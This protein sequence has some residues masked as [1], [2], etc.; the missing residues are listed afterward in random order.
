M[1]EVT[2][3]IQSLEK[4]TRAI[5]N[6]VSYSMRMYCR[7]DDSVNRELQSV[8]SKTAY[9]YTGLIGVQKITNY[10]RPFLDNNLFLRSKNGLQFWMHRKNGK[11]YVKIL[12]EYKYH[13]IRHLLP[14]DLGGSAKWGNGFWRKFQE[15]HGV[16]LYDPDH[17]Y[18]HSSSGKLRNTNFSALSKAVN[19]L[20]ES[21]VKVELSTGGE[22]L[23]SGL[24]FWD[25]FN[26]KNTTTLS[27]SGKALGIFG[28]GIT[29]FDNAK[30]HGFASQ[31]FVVDTA[32][33]IGTSAGAMALGAAAGSFI[34]P[35]A[36]TI[37]GAAVGLGINT[38][39]NH[40]FGH[41]INNSVV[42]FTK[43]IANK[44]VKN[45]SKGISSIC[46]SIGE[47]LKKGFGRW[48]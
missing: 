40:E 18:Y 19:N 31:E 33:D 8:Q 22:T 1:L 6:F 14:K 36:G 45:I 39:I 48:T 43:E 5:E 20:G 29:I 28:T 32:V 7:A 11:T 23:K 15:N 26:W 25:D 47:N 17:G 27:K 21:K 10:V 44:A 13:G 3:R 42:G 30:K 35:P 9:L 34:L 12:G 37:I 41:P 16:L 2:R 24:K 38:F 4:K 46:K